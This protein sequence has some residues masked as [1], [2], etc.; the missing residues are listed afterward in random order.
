MLDKRSKKVLWIFGIALLAIIV[1]EVVRPHPIDWRNSYTSFDKIPLG[2]FIFYE[3]A[4]AI[5]KTELEKVQEDP[6]EFLSDE[7]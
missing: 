6:F 5:F 2:S 3:E 1:T 4:T 7:K